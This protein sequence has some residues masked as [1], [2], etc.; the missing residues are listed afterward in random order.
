MAL[1]HSGSWEAGVR[2]WPEPEHMYR[3]TSCPKLPQSQGPRPPLS[4]TALC[5]DPTNDREV[6]GKE[7]SVMLKPIEEAGNEAEIKHSEELV[8]RSVPKKML[9]DGKKARQCE[10][11]GAGSHCPG[12]QDFFLTTALHA[13]TLR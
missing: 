8:E 13:G 2:S 11:G 7:K 9:A 12:L 3:C 6:L 5:F 10:Q 4:V 1:H